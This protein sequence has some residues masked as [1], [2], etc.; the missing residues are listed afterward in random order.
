MTKFELVASKTS[1]IQAR[2]ARVRLGLAIGAE[3]F[4]SR[5]DLVE[6]VAFN[7]L[8]AMQDAVDLGSHIVT[9]EGWGTPASLGD[10]FTFLHQ[11]GAI[12]AETAGAMR[13]GAK[14]RNLIARAYGDLDPGKLFSA[15]SAG[16]GQIERFLA[17]TGAWVAGRSGSS[18]PR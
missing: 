12:T 16:V 1:R 9:D 14:L 15:A 13:L 8:L 3:A 6:Q 2:L 18:A 5:I 10:T 7:M 17:E 4:P 11:H